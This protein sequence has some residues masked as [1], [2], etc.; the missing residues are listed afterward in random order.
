[1][2]ALRAL[3]AAWVLL[4]PVSALAERQCGANQDPSAWSA[5]TADEAQRCL[6]DRLQL[7]EPQ[8]CS[9][10]NRVCEDVARWRKKTLPERVAE[11]SQLLGTIRGGIETVSRDFPYAKPLGREL[12]RWLRDA[13]AARFEPV[14]QWRFNDASGRVLEN[15]ANEVDLV[16]ALNKECVTADACAK[17]LRGA[18]AT[19]IYARMAEVVAGDLLSEMRAEATAYIQMLDKR[20]DRY[21][22]TSRFQYPWELLINDRRFKTQ[23]QAGF[24]S[25]PEDQWIVMHPSAGLRYNPKGESTLEPLLILELAGIHR[26]KWSGADREDKLGGSLI[27]A[28][29]TQK[30]GNG[31]T[32]PGLGFIAYAPK[33]YAI[34]VL[35][36]TVAGQK[37]TSL[38]VNADVAK[39]FENKAA[40]RRTLQ[41]LL[42]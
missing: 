3:C 17:A 14:Q 24:V 38:I 30:G 25:P 7:V 41:G 26:W 18:G 8:S 20:W 2:S 29:A 36:H 6:T 9:A 10:Y 19:V 32:K 31:E 5:S 40:V 33:S 15:K 11:S 23:G 34:G 35:R 13:G 28:W 16:A 27:L 22:E 42:D 21:F 1:M 37:T 12:D 4:L 39:L